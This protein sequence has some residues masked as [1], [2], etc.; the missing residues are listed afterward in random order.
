VDFLNGG[1]GDDA[2]H[3]GAGD[4]GDGGAGADV[5]WLDDIAPGDPPAQ[6]MDY[7]PDEDAL[8]MLYDPMVHGNPVVSIH[9][10]EG[11]PD[12]VVLIDGVPVANVLGGAGLRAEDVSLLPG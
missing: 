7:R 11:S 12:A 8:V 9:S 5:F 10:D 1:E 6:I 4:H 3:L 2:L